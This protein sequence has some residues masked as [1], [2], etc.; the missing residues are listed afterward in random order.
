MLLVDHHHLQALESHV[1]LEQGVG[2]D[3]HLGPAR[4][5]GGEFPGTDSP[6]VAAGQEDGPDANGFQGAGDG[7]VVLAGEN[8]GGRHQGGLAAGRCHV[9]HGAHGDDGLA[10]THIALDQ[11]AHPLPGAEVPADLG[12]GPGLGAGEGEGQGG[13]DLVGKRAR[14]DAGGGLAPAGG[15]ALGHGQLV[16][17][18]FVVGEAPVVGA[19][20]RE[21]GFG[22][23][24]MEPRHRLAPRWEAFPGEEGRVLPFGQGGRPFQGFHGEG[25][26][27]AGRK[28]LGGWVDGFKLWNFFAFLRRDHVVRVDHLATVAVVADLAGDDTVGADGMAALKLVGEAAEE[29][30][31]HPAGG[32]GDPDAPGLGPAGRLVLLD[33]HLEGHHLTVASG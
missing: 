10:G 3:R 1:I 24:C 19:E 9:G 13:A 25:P 31:R 16:G 11:A 7:L 32:I 30:Q 22:F 29:H 33:N 17:E 8:F 26:H 12:Q 28:A 21:V 5:E 18:E 4:R 27:P 14:G 23:R 2:A 6:L 20:R 15:L